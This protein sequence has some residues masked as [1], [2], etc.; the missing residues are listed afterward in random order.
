VFEDAVVDAVLVLVAFVGLLPAEV[1][2]HF[3][4]VD[5]FAPFGAE[6]EDALDD[7][8]IVAAA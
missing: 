7:T 5:G 8:V 1:H 6:G 3:L 4:A 2:E